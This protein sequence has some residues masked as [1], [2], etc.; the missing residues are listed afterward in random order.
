MFF[1]K[2]KRHKLS[3]ILANNLAEIFIGMNGMVILAHQ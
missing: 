1:Y 2:K 3:L